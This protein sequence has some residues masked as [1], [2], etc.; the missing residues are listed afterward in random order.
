[1][2]WSGW[3]GDSIEGVSV[4]SREGAHV[5][6]CPPT[7]NHQITHHPLHTHTHPIDRS[8]HTPSFPLQAH[9]DDP[10]DTDEE[11]QTLPPFP[12]ATTGGGNSNSKAAPGGAGAGVTGAG[13]EGGGAGGGSGASW[14]LDDSVAAGSIRGA[15]LHV[16]C[17]GPYNKTPHAHIH[18][19]NTHDT[20]HIMTGGSSNGHPHGAAGVLSLK[21]PFAARDK[22]AVAF[23]LLHLGGMA[24]LLLLPPKRSSPSSTSSSHTFS[25]PLALTLA[26]LTGATLGATILRALLYQ[27]SIRK[28]LI[29]QAP[30]WSGGMQGALALWLL[31][32]LPWCVWGYVWVWVSMEGGGRGRG[33]GGVGVRVRVDVGGRGGVY[34]LT[35][36]PTHPASLLTVIPMPPPTTTHKRNEKTENRGSGAPHLFLQLGLLLLLAYN[37]RGEWAWGRRCAREGG[38]GFAAVLAG[39]CEGE[40]RRGGVMLVG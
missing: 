32:R 12:A 34:I 5:C 6:V 10:F 36:W 38:L 8:Q 1:M 20:Q 22:T 14:W 23:F 26:T 19:P 17:V 15:F 4:S 25:W 16:W 3:V 27:P 7:Q 31:L 28:A 24:W 2:V 37:A 11:S 29:R 30:F 21:R 40:G 33:C 35:D 39:R 18:S 9:H 13:E